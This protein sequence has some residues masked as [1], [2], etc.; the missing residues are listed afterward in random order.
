M[1]SSKQA[2]THSYNQEDVSNI[3]NFAMAQNSNFNSELSHSQ[4]LE[5]AREL[6]I[7]PESLELA[8]RQWLDRQIVVAKNREFEAYRRSRLQDRLGK[9]AIVNVCLFPLNL[10]TGF[11]VPWSLYVL[12]SWGTIRGID[13]W[14]VLF[15]HQGYAYDRAFQRWERQQKIQKGLEI[16]TISL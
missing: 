8:E 1:N 9:Y 11:G 10:L 4:L 2:L 6:S 5:V 3:L 15:G 12:I 14:R 13:A 16:S 7:D